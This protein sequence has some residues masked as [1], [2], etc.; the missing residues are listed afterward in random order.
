MIV[1][2]GSKRSGTSMWMQILVA[3][4]LAHI[5]EKFP[6]DWGEV[7]REQ[8]PGGFYESE[9]MAGVYY[10]TNPHPR[11]GDYLFPEATRSHAVKIFAPGLVRSDVAFLDRV[12]V[13]VRGVREYAR[14]VGALAQALGGEPALSAGL[15]WWTETFGMIRDIATRGY[16][17]HVVSYEAVLRDPRAR[18]SEVIDW[19]SVGDLD[20]ALAA[21]DPD[22]AARLL[23]RP[24]APAPADLS[25]SQLAAC[26]E[27]H[28]RIDEGEPLD[29]AFIDELNA[30]HAEISA[31]V[32]EREAARQRAVLAGVR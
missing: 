15:T 12:I 27:L 22:L 29:D 32:L 25:A 18:I 16:P 4:G 30:I 20:A 19:L 6:R 17:A 28:R 23:D 9:L 26:E 31:L 2:S 5:G 11:T 3:A 24:P 21:V 1:V 7:F 14:S 10:E 8:N 13:T